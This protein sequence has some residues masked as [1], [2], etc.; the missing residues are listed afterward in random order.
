MWRSSAAWDPI[1]GK[2]EAPD[3][4]NLAA[5]V[6]TLVAGLRGFA[7]DLRDYLARSRPDFL[8]LAICFARNPKAI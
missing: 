7:A 2:T 8:S 1:R 5:D 6:R 4:R 3:V